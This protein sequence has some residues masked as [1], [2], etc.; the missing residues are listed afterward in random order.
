[1]QLNTLSVISDR[2]NAVSFN[3]LLVC[4][5]KALVMSFN[6]LGLSVAVS[7]RIFGIL[8]QKILDKNEGI[9]L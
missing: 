3:I 6:S 2:M 1:M 7:A 5:W 8:S 4:I 9:S